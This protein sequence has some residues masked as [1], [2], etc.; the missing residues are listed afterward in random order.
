MMVTIATALTAASP[1]ALGRPP[2]PNRT[3]MLS[4]SALVTV[5]ALSKM[6]ADIGLS[7]RRLSSLFRRGKG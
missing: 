2:S 5:A 7:I 6:A 3:L 1:D 4:V